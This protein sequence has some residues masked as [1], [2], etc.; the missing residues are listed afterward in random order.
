LPSSP[1]IRILPS[2]ED[3]QKD[4]RKIL[5]AAL[6]EEAE[7]DWQK[8]RALG[9]EF[10]GR[11]VVV[12]P[13]AQPLTT[14]ELDALYSLPYQRKAH[15]SYTQPIPALRTVE[16][17]ITL[18]R[19]CFGG[20]TFC[21]LGAHQGKEIQSRS[22]RSVL[23]EI[24]ILAQ[25]PGFSGTI[26]D[27]G[28]PTANMYKLGCTKPTGPCRRPSCLFPSVCSYLLTDHQPLCD[29]LTQ[30]KDIPKVKHIFVASGIR[31]DLALKDPR[32]LATLVKNQHI[33]GSM[34]IAPEHVDD[35]VLRLMRKPPQGVLVRFLMEW[36]KLQPHVR[37]S[38]INAYF[39]SS[40][41][42]STVQGMKK[43]MN[44]ARTE[45]IE[46]GQMQD[47]I[48]LP[49]TLAGLMYFTGLDPFT[50]KPIPII[51]SAQER[52]KQ[53][54]QLVSITPDPRLRKSQKMHPPQ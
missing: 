12:Q 29:L 11:W 24:Q 35:Q 40:F 17:S 46:V 43:I 7:R 34:K 22:A 37:R 20:C 38:S 3:L 4:P 30:A 45:H 8:S 48:P 16:T 44:L 51:K 25:R 36:K 50:G 33:S 2:W 19:G 14:P 47:F 13:P 53:R 27:M 49:M 42:G 41:P 21:A 54:E 23:Q 1:K 10:Q 52:R 39:I 26:S 6:I 31:F 18:H 32:Y 15:P 9:Q 28:G 5:Q